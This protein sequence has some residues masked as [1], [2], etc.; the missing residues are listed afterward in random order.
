[1]ARH[2]VCW[3]DKTRPH[4]ISR[5]AN[6]D[7]SENL[8]PKIGHKNVYSKSNTSGL[9]FYFSKRRCKQILHSVSLIQLNFGNF[10]SDREGCY[11]YAGGQWL[12]TTATKLY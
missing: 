2:C 9:L 3:F 8:A 6:I 5:F 12:N 11:C 4:K 10:G 7:G 1:M